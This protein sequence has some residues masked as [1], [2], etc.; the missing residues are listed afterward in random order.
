MK[1]ISSENT[2]RDVVGNELL[3]EGNMEKSQRVWENHNRHR[4]INKGPTQFIN[5]LHYS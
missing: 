1:E 4:Y 3:T 2:V 5:R